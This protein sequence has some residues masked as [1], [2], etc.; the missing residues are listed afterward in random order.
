MKKLVSFILCIVFI[1]SVMTVL[2]INGSAEEAGLVLP[3]FDI[4]TFSFQTFAETKIPHEE[5]LS[6]FPEIIEIKY[7]NG[8]MYV[9][10]PGA[11]EAYCVE[12]G[13]GNYYDGELV[14]GYWRFGITEEEYASDGYV[15]LISDRN[16]WQVEYGFDG[17]RGI[18]H[19]SDNET[20]YKGI[21]FYPTE[22]YGEQYYQVIYE[23][24]VGLGITDN[25]EAGN[26]KEQT[27]ALQNSTESIWAEYTPEGEIDHITVSVYETGEY[28]Y[29]LPGN[30]W[31]ENPSE[32]VPVN[33]PKGHENDTLE[34]LLATV[35]TDIGCEH[36]WVEPDCDLPSLCSLCKRTKGE[37]EGHK[38]V[39]GKEYDT[40]T[41]C[42]GIRYGIGDVEIISPFVDRPYYELD[43]TGIDFDTI[44]SGF[45]KKLDVRYENGILMFPHIESF[46]FYAYG[47]DEMP[48]DGWNRVKV[49][50]DDL[51]DV[52][53]NYTYLADNSGAVVWYDLDYNHDGTLN[54]VNIYD[55]NTERSVYINV[56]KNT[57]VFMY[58]TKGAEDIEYTDTYKNG[59]LVS[60]TVDD[61]E[62]G[63]KVYYDS[64]LNIEKVIVFVDGEYVRLTP[65]TG[66]TVDED[67][68]SSIPAPE[69]YEDKGIGYFKET[70]PTN[71]DFC[72]HNWKEIKNGKECV[73]CGEKVVPE[74]NTV[75]IVT[76]SVAAVAIAVAA[77]IV[78][79]VIKKKKR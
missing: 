41:N 57:V 71:I 42:S 54:Y 60:Q 53:I 37:P 69:G 73:K 44:L 9:K 33:A 29:Y 72:I 13:E 66:W 36:D 35:P 45:P 68:G 30:G 14:D 76:A 7:E 58:P 65:E 63:V 23:L 51:E 10:D 55:E 48:S 34:T 3:E 2:P 78:I 18:L 21:Q 70:Y 56:V 15:S 74:S 39:S 27:V 4:P 40:C 38:W 50:E 62:K 11:E 32:Y 6:A 43:D 25:Y 79:V 1:S 8:A 28:A 19:V 26:L 12:D 5:I 47:G 61:S 64:D 52:D 59:V 22:G 75:L 17:N 24:I 31:S 16:G 46:E 49:H 20:I 67:E 77:I